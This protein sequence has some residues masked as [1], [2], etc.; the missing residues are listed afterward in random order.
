ML[1]KLAL[2]SAKNHSTN[3]R[4]Q[5]KQRRYVDSSSFKMAVLFAVLLGVAALILV[6]FIYS[7]SKGMYISQDMVVISSEVYERIIIFGILSI[8]AL[9]LVV[10]ISFMLSCF[11]VE[12]INI[13]A[14]TAEDIMSTGD[15]SRR[16][17]IDTKWDDLSNLADILNQLFARIEHSM[18]DVRRV[19]DSIAHDLRT[20]LTRLKNSLEETKGQQKIT[21]SDLEK[22][23][24]AT[25]QILASFN[26]LLRITNIE[27]G[28]RHS[29]FTSFDLSSVIEDIVE[30]YEPIA[31][32]KQISITTELAPANINADR[33]L[34]FQ[35][36]ANILDNALK[37][38]P[39]HGTV[40][41][42]V[43]VKKH[44][45]ILTISDSGCGIAEEHLDKIFARFFRAE[46]NRKS[47]GS[48]LGLSLVSA[49]I[50]L[51]NAKI[52][53]YNNPDQGSSFTIEF[54]KC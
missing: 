36:I 6:Y 21:S 50:K 10:V 32:E 24:V 12:R 41:C 25:D 3:L 30:L 8:I 22:S 20:P 5:L 23:I 9:S 1:N 39:K 11:V 4:K 29:K 16:I 34:I 35:A 51:H 27:K 45:V 53:V 31:D 54:A 13:I 2:G 18:E 7:Y 15:L 42:V 37:F 17:S 48:G 28:K 49:I 26:A 40:N 38:T 46:K 52:R 19:S 43:E 44:V 33:D 14:G 47:P